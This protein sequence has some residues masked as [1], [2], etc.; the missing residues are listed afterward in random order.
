MRPLTYKIFSGSFLSNRPTLAQ[1]C[2]MAFAL[3]RGTRNISSIHETGYLKI[4]IHPHL[5]HRIP[6]PWFVAHETFL[7]NSGCKK[8][9]S[10]NFSIRFSLNLHIVI[11][12]ANLQFK[13]LFRVPRPR[14]GIRQPHFIF[15]AYLRQ[16]GCPPC[17]YMLSL[18]ISST[19][20]DGV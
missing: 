19:V 9:S 8:I 1:I 16:E 3:V 18:F 4:Q 2:S 6:L 12:N 20:A 10:I 15:A 5:F 11:Y 17:Y 13:K 7:P 14:R